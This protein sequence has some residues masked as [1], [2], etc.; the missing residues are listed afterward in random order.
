MDAKKIV[1]MTLVVREAVNNRVVALPCL[2]AFVL[3]MECQKALKTNR[4]I[5]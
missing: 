3:V 2:K 5:I 4:E 1:G